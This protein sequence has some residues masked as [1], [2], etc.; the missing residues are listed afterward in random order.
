VADHRIRDAAHQRPP[1]GPKVP[2]S[3]DDEPGSEL[4]SSLWLVAWRLELSS[5]VELT[6]TR[7][8]HGDELWMNQPMTRPTRG[9]FTEA[10]SEAV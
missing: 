9:L 5:C 2:T 10:C 1:Q 7:A 8:T 4:M 3:Q 6:P